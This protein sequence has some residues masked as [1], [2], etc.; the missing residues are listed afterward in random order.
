MTCSTGSPFINHSSYSVGAPLRTFLPRTAASS[1][2]ARSRFEPP[3][4]FCC[5]APFFFFF[6][7]GASGAG[8]FFLA[9]AGAANA[10]SGWGD[11]VGDAD[12][13]KNA[14]QMAELTVWA[15]TKSMHASELDVAAMQDILVI[16]LKASLLALQNKALVFSE[17]GDATED[18]P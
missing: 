2:G 10:P 8:R 5:F 14:E 6:A 7:R 11:S 15:L 17:D 9:G 3:C 1:P 18:E 16:I 4:R 13:P 12:K